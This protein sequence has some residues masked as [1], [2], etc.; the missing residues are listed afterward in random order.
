MNAVRV[1]PFN[2]VIDR[3]GRFKRHGGDI[4]WAGVREDTPLMSV[5]RELTTRLTA[6][7]F[8]L[9]MRRYS[10]H[11]TLGRE[12]VTDYAFGKIEPFGERGESIELMKSERV[13]GKLTYT[14]IY[15]KRG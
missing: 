13:S 10:P 1:E 5:Q 14:A 9:E 3:I 15:E 6:A 4:W 11:I 7:G 2:A 12:V 8:T